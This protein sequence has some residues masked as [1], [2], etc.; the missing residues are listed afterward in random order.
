[1]W[2]IRIFPA[3]IQHPPVVEH[4]GIF[5][6]IY[7]H[8]DPHHQ[9]PFLYRKPLEVAGTTKKASI[10]VIEG[11]RD[12]LVPNNATRSLAW[13]VGPIPHM[14]PIWEPSAFLDTVAG[15]VRGNIDSDTTAALYQYVPSGVPDI[16]ATPGCEFQPEG[17]FCPQDAPD[18]KRQ[19]LLF[20]K[21]AVEDPVPT[22]LDPF[23]PSP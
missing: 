23:A 21:S 7:D 10:L 18:A 17:H 2:H 5:Q 3:L 4:H 9:A 22:I 1:M 14:E 12:T 6:M 16:P 13:T 19:R 8:Q 20:L 11:L 15:P